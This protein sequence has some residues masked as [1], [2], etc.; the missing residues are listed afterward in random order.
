MTIEEATMTASVS[1]R[2]AGPSH[3]EAY[4]MLAASAERVS[5]RGRPRIS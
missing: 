5:K 1:Q 2:S 4:G 3:E